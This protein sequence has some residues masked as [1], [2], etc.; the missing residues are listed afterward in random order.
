LSAPARFVADAMLGSLAR[1]L[2]IFGIDTLYFREGPDPELIALARTEGRVILTSDRALAAAARRRGV[3][4]LLIE[5][6][7]DRQRLDSLAEGA[8][9]ESVVLKKDISRCALCNAPLQSLR[10]AEIGSELLG[11]VASRHRVYFRCPDCGK[12]Y[13][14]GGHWRRLSRMSSIL[15]RQ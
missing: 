3:T 7:G 10:R 14:K 6:R 9:R 13:W 5:G 4:A 1:K 15:S 2:R 12:L 11:S 8:L